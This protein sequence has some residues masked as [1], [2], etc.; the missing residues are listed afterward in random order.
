MSRTK[1]CAEPS[2]GRPYLVRGLLGLGLGLLLITNLAA[3]PR[4]FMVGV[5]AQPYHPYYSVVNGEYASFAREL[6]DAFAAARGYQ[7]NYVPLPVKRLYGNFLAG[8]LDFKFPDHPQWHKELKQPFDIHYSDPVVPFIDGLLVDPA[9]LGQGVERIKVVGTP[10]G[11]TPAIIQAQ[12]DEGEI[13]L[14]EV[15][16]VESLLKMANMG[17]VDAVYMN[18]L[19]ARD[20]LQQLKLPSDML[21]FDPSLPHVKDF[22]YFSSIKYPEIIL[23]FNDFLREQAVQVQALQQKFA[24]IY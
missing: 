12:I 11:F 22:F 9:Q 5:E 14:R 10:L 21:V 8:K 19:V 2:R 3:A 1:Q 6:L 23:E 15:S 7:F 20:S 18:P 13:A 24:I 4:E 16:K 17:R